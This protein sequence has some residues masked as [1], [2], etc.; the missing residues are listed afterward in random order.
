MGHR[1]HNPN[2]PQ[3]YTMTSI[4]T[5]LG[6]SHSASRLLP[7]VSGATVPDPTPTAD[8]VTALGG[9]HG[10]SRLLPFVK[11]AM[12]EAVEPDTDPVEPE[13]V[14]LPPSEA[15]LRAVGGDNPSDALSF[16]PRTSSRQ[17][18][19]AQFLAAHWA[20]L[21]PVLVDHLHRKLSQTRT[22]GTAEDHVGGFAA[23]LLASDYLASYIAGGHKVRANVLKVW[24]YQ[25][26]CSEMRGWGTDASL[27]ETRGATTVSDRRGGSRPSRFAT[28]KVIRQY[29]DGVEMGSDIT[30]GT[31]SSPEDSSVSSE[32]LARCN[33]A[34]DRAFRADVAP[35]YRQL[36]LLEV[37]DTPRR[38]MATILGVDES[39]VARMLLNMRRA[40]RT[41]VAAS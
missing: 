26:A 13:P 33:E 40:L 3:G 39:R 8:P 23:K 30:D 1:P 35:L 21:R 11:A 19:T 38:D 28:A 34:L 17:S 10:A 22:L 4:T 29:E 25:F 32:S 15:D 41:V 12:S 27:R 9:P 16:T 37:E 7:F 5:L 31:V 20:T 18:V 2:H 36:L 14:F 6:G 24:A